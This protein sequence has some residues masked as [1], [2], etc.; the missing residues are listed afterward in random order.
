MKTRL[1]LCLLCLPISLLAQFTTPN[2]GLTYSLDDLV[3]ISD[4]VVSG[5]PDIY[6]INDTVIIAPTDTLQIFSDPTVEIAP[7]V[8]VTIQGGFTVMGNALFT[9]VEDLGDYAGF[10]FE[11]ESTINLEGAVFEYG[12][13][14][15]CIT[16]NL[17]MV[18]CIVRYQ[19]TEAATGGALALSNGNPIISNTTF[20]QNESAAIGSSG[21]GEI[22][23]F[24][25]DCTFIENNTANSNRPQINLGPSGTDTIRIL[26][27]LIQGNPEN[28]KVGGIAVTSFFGG[29]SHAIISGNEIRDN[30]YGITA[31]GNGITTSITN[32]IIED[33]DTEDLPMVGGSGINIFASA[34]NMHV[35]LNNEIRGNL[36]GITIQG[37]G[38]VN[39]GELDNEDIGAGGNIFS[40][41]ENGGVVYA[42]Y[43]NTPNTVYAQGNCW[44]E[45]SVAT[46]E[47]VANVIVDQTDIDSLGVVFHGENACNTVGVEELNFSQVALI[48][49]NPTSGHVRITLLV[50]AERIS[51]IDLSGREVAHRSVIESHDVSMELST[52]SPG[53]YLVQIV[54]HKFVSTGKLLVQ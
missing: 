3:S 36:W 31:Y 47:D 26:N 8:L 27:N 25:S 51:I 49:P 6:T 10:R 30:R 44:L 46:L 32:N 1:L 11:E 21:N 12:G 42:L 37:N 2:T 18:D 28:V 17:Q 39:L 43:N 16:G 52:L 48:Y 20:L 40:G 14:L 9:R 19:S 35:I 7:N 41:N 15:K 23:P 38:M 24:I 13:G 53:I 54:G 4:G 50:P 29:E 33:N 22:A 34:E 45:D 5:G